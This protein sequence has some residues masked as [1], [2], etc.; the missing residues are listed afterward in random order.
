MTCIHTTL[1]PHFAFGICA[2]IRTLTPISA[3]L[4][5][6]VWIWNWAFHWFFLPF[7]FSALTP[8]LMSLLF[9]V[10][11][12][13]FSLVISL[14]CFAFPRGALEAFASKNSPQKKCLGFPRSNYVKSLNTD[15]LD[16][17]ACASIDVPACC[18]IFCLATVSYTHLTLPT[19]REV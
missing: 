16:M 18:K 6:S 1:R 5:A 3:P 2:S 14:L 9:R 8:Y 15:W 19:N 10:P 13:I 7:G 17:F 12:R 4:L 11:A